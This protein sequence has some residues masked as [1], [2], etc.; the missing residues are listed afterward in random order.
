V[1]AAGQLVVG[2]L[3]VVAFF[4]IGALVEIIATLDLGASALCAVFAGLA[5]VTLVAIYPTAG[6]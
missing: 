5:T 6:K 3:L 1:T 2:A 4:A